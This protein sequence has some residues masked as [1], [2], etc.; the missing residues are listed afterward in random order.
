ML[1][2]LVSAGQGT[3]SWQRLTGATSQ[4]STELETGTYATIQNGSVA[5]RVRWT[6]SAGTAVTTDWIIPAYGRFDW[7][8]DDNTKFVNAIAADGT[9]TFELHVAST[10]VRGV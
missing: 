2:P 5:I 6:G 4:S 3:R 8:T 10:S 1:A 7:S 9:S